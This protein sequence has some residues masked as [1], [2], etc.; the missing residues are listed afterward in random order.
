MF[1]TLKA[2]FEDRIANFAAA[3]APIDALPV[4]VAALM[5][6]IA[7]ADDNIGDDERQ[8]ILQAVATACELDDTALDALVDTANDAADESVSLYEFT[9]IINEQLS[10]EKK[11]ELLQMLW[12]VAR[13]DGR[14]DHYEEYYIRK[15]AD[16]LHLSHS[17]FIR[18]KLAARD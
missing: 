9:V 14:V 16:L 8:A 18:A 13:A 12:R 10:R 4:A 1:R 5:F 6:E 7:K 15:I 2:L 17:D 3:T 11:V